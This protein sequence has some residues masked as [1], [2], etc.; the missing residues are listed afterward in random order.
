MNENPTTDN[1]LNKEPVPK[2][3]RTKIMVLIVSILMVGLIAWASIRILDSTQP[4]ESVDQPDS[5]VQIDIEATKQAADSKLEAG[6]I[7][8]ALQDYQRAYDASVKADDQDQPSEMT[9]ELESQI[10]MLKA[11]SDQRP[12][13]NQDEITIPV[14]A[15]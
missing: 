10:E 5:T 8:A 3:S 2:K 13:D 4:R 12:D 9:L 15:S 11:M 1:I 14:T 7:D 6:E